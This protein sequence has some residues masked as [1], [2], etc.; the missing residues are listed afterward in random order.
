[1][2]DASGDRDDAEGRITRSP[3][4]A[5]ALFYR[6]SVYKGNERLKDSITLSS[7]EGSMRDD[8]WRTTDE[9]LATL[10]SGRLLQTSP[11]WRAR[12]RRGSNWRSA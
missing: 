8:D 6:R 2:F 9:Q 10:T 11:A 4:V 5:R 12:T 7:S 1:M 3:I